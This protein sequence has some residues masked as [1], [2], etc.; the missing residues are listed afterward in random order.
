MIR[1]SIMLKEFKAFIARGNV[2]DLAIAVIMGAA[3]GTI[4]TSLVNDLV[5]PPVGLL[6]GKVDFANLFI[7]LSSTHY[8][9]LKE[10]KAA[11]AATI[12]YG[13]FLNAIINFAIISFAAFMIVRL[14]NKMKTPEPGAP[15]TTKDCPR[16]LSTIPIAATRCA[17]CTVD[18]PA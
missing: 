3:F 2:L 17:H 14:A 12:N 16:C 6:I 8:A 15:A 10:A 5:M 9:T 11:G 18:L 13:A 1:F 7:N 4:V